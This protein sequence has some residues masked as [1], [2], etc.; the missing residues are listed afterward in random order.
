[1]P[2]FFVSMEARALLWATRLN[3]PV[4]VA[5]RDPGVTKV[6]INTSRPRQ[7][8]SHYGDLEIHFL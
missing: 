4:K 8:G 6:G 2:A 7:I 5:G 1:M 3:V